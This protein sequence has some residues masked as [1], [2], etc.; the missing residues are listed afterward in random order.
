MHKDLWL[1][2]LLCVDKAPSRYEITELYELLS[3]LN[4]KQFCTPKLDQGEQVARRI[5]RNKKS[6]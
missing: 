1:E 6:F 2:L 3:R 4:V 5:Y